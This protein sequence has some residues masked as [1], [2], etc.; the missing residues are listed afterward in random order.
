MKL[1]TSVLIATSIYSNVAF[2]DACEELSESYPVKSLPL[3]S[4]QVI[5]VHAI[6]GINAEIMACERIGKNWKPLFTDP[7][8]SVIGANGVATA[9]EKKEGDRKTPA[10]LYPLG[11][12]FGTQPLALHMDYRYITSEDKFI[13]DSNSKDYNTWVYG[14]TDAKSYESML[15]DPYKLGA[16]IQYN[17][18]PVIAGK[19]SAIFMH[20]WRNPIKPTAGCVAMSE[21]SLLKILQWVDKAQHP[22]VYIYK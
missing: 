13:D 6:G 16:V 20:I 12:A 19:G 9:E 10:G 14:K 7:I 1:I 4:S 22:Y 8:K 18:N 5:M 17:M 15:R 3:Q 11:E 21:S 2:A